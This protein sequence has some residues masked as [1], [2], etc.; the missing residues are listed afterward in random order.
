M[1]APKE[2]CAALLWIAAQRSGDTDCTGSLIAV[3]RGLSPDGRYAVVRRPGQDPNPE[4]GPLL[5]IRT[6]DLA[7]GADHALALRLPAGL[8]GGVVAWTGPSTLVLELTPGWMQKGSL[9]R[10]DVS[11]RARERAGPIPEPGI[12]IGPKQA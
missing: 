6:D 3:E 10:C 1:G 12:L 11:T 2:S 5:V 8:Q 7:R 9:V 4:A